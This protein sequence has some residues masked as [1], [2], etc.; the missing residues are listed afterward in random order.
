[1]IIIDRSKKNTKKWTYIEL[2]IT[3]RISILK[4]IE[5]DDE[6]GRRSTHTDFTPPELGTT[7]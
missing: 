6:F 3:A 4:E 7:H 1:M 5:R 2:A